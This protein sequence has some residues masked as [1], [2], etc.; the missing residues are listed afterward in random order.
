MP[1]S[2]RVAIIGRT[3]RGDY[4]HGLDNVWVGM[5]NVEIVALADE[6]EKGRIAA[7]S[8]VKPKNVY[9]D[10]R[11]MLEKERPQI[12]SVAAR[13][14]DCHR[15][16]VIACAE[17]GA[18]VFMEKPMC[19]TLAEAD[20]MVKACE[21]HHIK[22]A[23]AH[24]THY[25]PRLVWVKELLA[26]GRIGA[27]L[28]MRGRGKEDARGGGEDLMV[29]GSHIMDLMRMFAGDP[30]WCFATVALE[31]KSVTRA[32]VRAGSEGIGPLAGDN[33]FAA[34]G[35]G[36]GVHGTFATVRD[37]K[38]PVDTTR[39]LPGSRFGLHLFGSRGMVTMTTGSLPAVY[40]C[41]DASWSP[42]HSKT[43]W[44]E[45]TSAG[46]GQPEPLKDGSAH[47]GNVWIVKDLMEAIE[48][49]RQP[50]CSVYDG[51]WTIE[52]ILGVYESQRL[53]G[54]AQLP[55]KNRAHPLELL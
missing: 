39:T 21:R 38:Q 32:E 52:M 4:G 10:Y 50:L 17:A 48:Q 16:M 27:L 20:D 30:H 9:A 51:R 44:K 15:E 1:K 41:E 28:E 5:D 18:H 24:Q 46:I 2:Y 6:N 14:L 26:S 35:F 45:I 29:L 25:S 22:L 7:A 43:A 12:V 49:D 31:G 34:Y 40:L 11:L 23:L 53:K 33:I 19:R 55:L 42:G 54:P 36:K 3:G 47:A 37:R 8:R 13:W